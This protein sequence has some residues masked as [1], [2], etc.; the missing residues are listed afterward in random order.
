MAKRP[1]IGV[2]GSSRRW[3]PSW[4]CTRLAVWLAGGKALRIH[5]GS[6]AIPT[7][8]DG[9]IIGGGDDIDPTLYDSEEPSHTRIDYE[10][11][12]LEVEFIEKALVRRIPILG[13][14]RGAQLLNVVLGGTLHPDI[15][16]MRRLT[17][18]RSSLLATKQVRLVIGSHL[19]NIFEQHSIRV[20]SLHKQAVDELGQDLT[21]AGRDRDDIIQCIEE[22]T[23]LPIVGV[24]WHPEYLF[25]L[26]AQMRLFSWLVARSR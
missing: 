21:V 2:T 14:C 16:P 6:R 23:G 17:R 10:R 12:Q 19:A 4:S 13:I 1:L 26:P 20:N 18:N 22:R 5:T 25:Y 11:D 9:I 15:R 7:R 3:S 24:Q 8:L